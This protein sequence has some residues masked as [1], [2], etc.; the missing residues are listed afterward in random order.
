[1]R[2]TDDDIY[3]LNYELEVDS[4]TKAVNIIQV[5]FRCYTEPT[6]E[7]CKHI[8]IILE[9]EDICPIC[10]TKIGYIGNR[11]TVSGNGL[12]PSRICHEDCIDSYNKGKGIEYKTIVS[13]LHRE[14]N[15]ALELHSKY[16]H[17]LTR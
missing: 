4:V 14:Y 16:G 15:K 17:W 5:E 13:F 11:C 8:D 7:Q 3:M 12:Y 10:R 9:C 1:M 2:S 6:K